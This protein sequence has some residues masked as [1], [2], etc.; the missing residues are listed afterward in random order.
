MLSSAYASAQ[1]LLSDNTKHVRLNDNIHL[2]ESATASDRFDKI[3]RL[4]QQRP[5]STYSGSHLGS[6][7]RHAWLYAQI[8]NDSFEDKW[9]LTIENNQLDDLDV[10]LILENRLLNQTKLLPVVNTDRTFPSFQMTLSRGQTYDLYVRVESKH[11]DLIV[12]LSLRKMDS[13]IQ[14]QRHRYLTNG[15]LYGILGMV[16]LQIIFSLS[17]Y[18][19]IQ[20]LPFIGLIVTAAVWQLS[21]QGH[22]PYRIEYVQIIPLLAAIMSG[23]N[24]VVTAG[25][26][27]RFSF[28]STVWGLMVIN[29]TLWLWHCI[30]SIDWWLDTSV[31]FGF[32]MMSAV[33]NIYSALLC[34]KCRE[35]HICFAVLANMTFAIGSLFYLLV[36]FNWLD[37]YH[38]AQQTLSFS[39]IFS[40]LLCTI[41]IAIKARMELRMEVLQATNDAENNVS[42]IEEQNVRLDIARRDAVKASKVKSQFLANMSHEIRTP[43]NAIIGFSKELM[44]KTNPAERDDHYRI[45]NSAAADLLTIVNDILDFSKME[46]GKHTL[47]AKPFSLRDTFDDIAGLTAKSAHLKRLEFV[48]DIEP[49]PDQVI[50]DAFKLKQLL[51]NLLSNA[52]KFTNYGSVS[53]SA[54]KVFQTNA[55]IGLEITVEDTGIGINPDDQKKLFTPFHQLDDD[56]NRS[57]Q[58]TGLGL[59]ICQELVF[60]MQGEIE[61]ESMPSVGSKF[62]V[63]LPFDIQQKEGSTGNLNF[64]RASKVGI[65]DPTPRSRMATARQLAQIG[66]NT[67]SYE[68][69]QGLLALQQQFEVCFV[70]LPLRHINSRVETIN[71]AFQID[72]EILVFLYSGPAPE[73]HQIKHSKI[74]PVVLRAPLTR[75]NLKHIFEQPDQV[76]QAQLN[77]VSPLQ[78]LPS[79][80]ILAVDDMQINLKLLETWFKGTKL[81][82]DTASSGQEA[83]D[84]SKHTAYDL[85]LMDIQMPMMDGLQATKLIRKTEHNL[86]TPIIA[87]TAHAF[88]EERQHFL[89]SGMDDYIP[90]PIDLENLIKLLET[91]CSNTEF[92]PDEE[93]VSVD[94]HLARKRCNDDPQAA[95]DYMQQFIELLPDTI[96]EIESLW[97]HQDLAGLKA[98]IHKLHGACCYTGVPHLQTYCHNTETALKKKQ[99]SDMSRLLSML[100]LEAEKVM[101]DWQQLKEN[102]SLVG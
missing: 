31:L 101:H 81:Q 45:I 73:A 72:T 100:L 76:N 61:V 77:A 71:Q 25:D 68:S 57:F 53:L 11:A 28:T 98:C 63:K 42:I 90:K 5:Y 38:W 66:A 16:L 34:Y 33:V 64:W 36:L 102:V 82:L 51:N 43:L 2:L 21:E 6:Q 62:I 22:I 89:A 14:Y 37:A 12:P 54:R 46:A 60:L 85:I 4:R 19:Y 49:M 35:L 39:V 18:A 58:G 95:Y 3:Q 50:G 93:I 97:Q 29:L 32:A 96:K 67:T 55:N 10:F 99:I 40:T 65:V 69:L 86:G 78:S 83:V 15:V 24:M 91:W 44:N 17:N 30:V 13:F 26:N 47:N 9:A 56:L 27:K 80:K 94:W 59:V 7:R 20:R 87:V 84:K 75:Q 41:A 52:L 48:F 23:C 79:A 88:A 70:N 8:T 92:T 1:I 74:Q